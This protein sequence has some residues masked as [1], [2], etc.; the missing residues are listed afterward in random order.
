MPSDQNT[1]SDEL[2]LDIESDESGDD[3]TNT[4]KDDS[5]EVDLSLVDKQE[6]PAEKSAKDQEN[7]WYADIIAGKRTIEDLKAS[8]LTWLLPRV[9]KRLGANEKTPDIEQIVTKKLQEQREE[10]DFKRMQSSIPKLSPPQ[11]DQLKRDFAELVNAGA[12]RVT[13]LK[14]AMRLNG[15]G[16]TPPSSAPLP[17]ASRP[18]SKGV[19][20]MDTVSKDDK[21][22]KEFLKDPEAFKRKHGME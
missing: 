19:L 12:K 7:R 9:E 2:D 13:A 16:E 5:S 3:Q 21:L 22:W 8:H 14:S 17:P 4:D 18:S 20:D 1:A 6:T 15:I 11:A 10:E